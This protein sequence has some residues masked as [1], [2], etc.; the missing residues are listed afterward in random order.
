M[1]WG[2]LIPRMTWCELIPRISH[3]LKFEQPPEIMVIHCGG[4]SIGH[5]KLHH[6]R[7]QIK[8]AIFNLKIMLPNTKFIWSHILPRYSW[9]YSKNS[10]AMNHA[11]VR[12]NNYA[13]SLIVGLGGK[14]IKYPE[15]SWDNRGMFANDGV[16]LSQL[17]NSFFLYNLQLTLS[18]ITMQY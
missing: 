10:K 6:L 9:G 18:E 5:I 2:E 8:D 11:A 7:C 14:Y 3:L 16:H 13:A 17:G 1:T 12:L 15:I 4:N